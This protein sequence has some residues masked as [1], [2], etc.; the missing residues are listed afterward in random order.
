MTAHGR[1]PLG[2][3]TGSGLASRP[4]MTH[5]GACSLSESFSGPSHFPQMDLVRGLC[6][7][8]PSH[9]GAG[10]SGSPVS[11]PLLAEKHVLG[12]LSCARETCLRDSSMP[13]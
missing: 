10:D 12:L 9:K 2:S 13:I 6:A 7:P 5:F 11:L 4:V 1:R 8:S 3:R